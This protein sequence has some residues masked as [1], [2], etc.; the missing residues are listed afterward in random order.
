MVSVDRFLPLLGKQ[1][2]QQ[3]HL[4]PLPYV[5][6]LLHAPGVHANVTTLIMELVARL[7]GE[8]V[9]EEDEGDEPME[10]DADTPS[11]NV[12]LSVVDLSEGED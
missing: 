5:F 2:P 11:L 3:R 7:L 6:K 4:T 12:G 10:T 1:H 8:T 9:G